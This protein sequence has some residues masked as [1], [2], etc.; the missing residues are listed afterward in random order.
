ML[1]MRPAGLAVWNI[2]LADLVIANGSDLWRAVNGDRVGNERLI[3]EPTAR[4]AVDGKA[5]QK[6]WE[7]IFKELDLK[8]SDYFSEAEWH[9]WNRETLWGML[10]N[11]AEDGSERFG[12][13]IPDPVE[14]GNV[15]NALPKNQPK[16]LPKFPI[17]TTV[18]LEVDAGLSGHLILLEQNTDGGID[19]LSPSVLMQ[20]NLLTGEIQY[21]PQRPLP[22]GMSEVIELEPVGTRYLW[23]GIFAQLPEWGWLQGAREDLLDL[24]VEQLTD[25]LGYAQESPEGCRMWKTSYEVV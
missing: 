4:N 21:L 7:V 1:K 20:D 8:W 3:S 19:L 23:A 24:Q 14:Y 17:K 11:S 22:E 13:V 5:S 6:K 18:I 12:L 10:L 15:R 9:E 16:Y 25:L 2:T